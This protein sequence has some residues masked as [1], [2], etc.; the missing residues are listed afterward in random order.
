MLGQPYRNETIVVFANCYL[1][2]AVAPEGWN[3]YKN[4]LGPL[5]NFRE[6]NS[7]GPGARPTRENGKVFNVTVPVIFR[8]SYFIGRAR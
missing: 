7:R 5:N 3:Q 4:Y 8:P 1:G 6:Y 2:N